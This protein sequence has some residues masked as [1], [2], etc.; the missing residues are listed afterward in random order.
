MWLSKKSVVF[1]GFM[2]TMFTIGYYYNPS[3]DS[4]IHTLNELLHNF[5][6]IIKYARWRFSNK[7]N[8]L[9]VQDN[10]NPKTRMYMELPEISMTSTHSVEYNSKKVSKDTISNEVIK[11]YVYNNATMWKLTLFGFYVARENTPCSL[12]FYDY[13]PLSVETGLYARKNKTHNSICT[14]YSSGG[15]IWDSP[16]KFSIDKFSEVQLT[17]S[18]INKQLMYQYNTTK[19]S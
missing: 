1:V 7:E 13:I 19:R 15:L 18:I 6:D 17:V 5:K 2:T 16:E 10:I 8:K 11:T 14:T 3:M 12:E 9:F 4:A